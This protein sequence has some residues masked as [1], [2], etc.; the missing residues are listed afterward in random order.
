MEKAMALAFVL[1]AIAVLGAAFGQLA[2]KKGIDGLQGKYSVTD[3]L[4]P[5]N[6]P[7]IFVQSPLV[8]AGLLIYVVGFLVWIAALSALD[9]SFMYPLLSLSYVLLAIL[10]A[11]F[12]KETITVWRWAGIVLVTIGSFLLLRSAT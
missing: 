5:W 1:L 12:L 3:I 2:L 7:K 4:K 8:F 6:L 10:A 9:V 11:V